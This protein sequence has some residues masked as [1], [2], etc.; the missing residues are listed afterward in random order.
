MIGTRAV[1]ERVAARYIQLASSEQK[2]EQLG[3][4]FTV[5]GA[6]SRG[7]DAPSAAELFV[8]EF[9]ARTVEY[10]KIA[11]FGCLVLAALH[12]WEVVRLSASACGLLLDVAGA[13][14]LLRGSLRGPAAIKIDA[15]IAY[16]HQAEGESFGD[17]A[18]F[19]PIVRSVAA[20]TVDA[21]YGGLFLVGGFGLQF[22]AAANIL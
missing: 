2:T 3:R 12:Y 16:H 21:F 15:G 22:V 5:A 6:I 18:P 4:S 7:P 1:T 13:M 14:L 8:E 9:D 10:L 19:E 17:D 20:R 11:L